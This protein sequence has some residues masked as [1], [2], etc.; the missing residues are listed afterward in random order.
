MSHVGM[1]L[2]PGHRLIRLDEYGLGELLGMVNVQSGL[3]ELS[4]ELLGL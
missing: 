4:R 2:I 1:L 3:I